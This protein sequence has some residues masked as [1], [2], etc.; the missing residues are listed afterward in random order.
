MVGVCNSES[1]I[2]NRSTKIRL[3]SNPLSYP[4]IKP[5]PKKTNE[6]IEIKSHSGIVF[7]P[8]NSVV[9]LSLMIRVSI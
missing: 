3:L 6:K 8:E 5:L 2:P 4:S 9:T 1:N 7:H